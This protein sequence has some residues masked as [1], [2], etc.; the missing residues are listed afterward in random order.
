LQDAADGGGVGAQV[1]G[2]PDGATAL[3]GSEGQDLGLTRRAGAVR[4]VMGA[5]GAVQQTRFTLG[6]IAANPTVGRLAG[7]PELGCDMR[8]RALLGA[9]DEQQV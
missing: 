1:R 8:D 5:A 6:V 9:L 2:E 3:H 7:D 4:R